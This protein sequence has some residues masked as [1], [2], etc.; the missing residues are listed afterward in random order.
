MGD[1]NPRDQEK[2]LFGTVE[3]EQDQTNYRMVVD[4]LTNLLTSWLNNRS[5]FLLGRKPKD[6]TKESR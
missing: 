4:Y 2:P 5:Y 1:E 6:E 3:D